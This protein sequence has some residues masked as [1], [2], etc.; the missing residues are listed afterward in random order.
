MSAWGWLGRAS[1]VLPGVDDP[2]AAFPNFSS[3][4]SRR[5]RRARRR[6][7]R[8]R[9]EQ[10]IRS[11]KR[12]TS[13]RNA[14]CSRLT[15]P[16]PR[17]NLARAPNRRLKK[18]VCNDYSNRPRSSSSCFCNSW[19]DAFIASKSALRDINSVETLYASGIKIEKNPT[20]SAKIASNTPT[21]ATQLPNIEDPYSLAWMSCANRSRLR[22]V[23]GILADL[24]VSGEADTRLFPPYGSG[25]CLQMLNKYHT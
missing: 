10:I 9:S 13:R 14:R 8:R 11:R 22:N 16:K 15:I 7:G 6:R 2:L 5:W 21:L 17:C 1:R 4:C 23:L 19:I 18:T 24:S 12:W 25:R 3:A 20:M